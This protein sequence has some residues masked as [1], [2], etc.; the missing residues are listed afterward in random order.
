MRNRLFVRSG[1][2][3]L[4]LSPLLLTSCSSSVGPTNRQPGG[5]AALTSIQVTP[6]NSSVTAGGTAQFEAIGTFSDKSTQDLTSS[7]AWTSSN[8]AAATINATGL[9]TGVTSGQTTTISAN[10]ASINGSTS[11]S[12][13]AA[14]L[15]SIAVTPGNDSIV[16]GT[17]VQFKAMGTFSNNSTQDLTSSVTWASSNAA[18]ATINATGLATGVTS[19]QTATIS[20]KQGSTTGSTSLSVAAATLV[21]IVVTPSNGSVVAKGTLQFTATGTFSNNSTQDLTSSVTWSF[22]EHNCSNDQR[23]WIG[24]RSDFGADHNNFGQTGLHDWIDKPQCGRSNSSFDCRNSEQWFDGGKGHLA[25]H[26][27]RNVFKQQH[28]GSHEFGYL[29][30]RRTQLQQRSARPGW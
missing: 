29:E 21:S 12:V 28:T 18:A 20:A 2:I 4:S 26:G 19:G 9:A 16:T 15:V 17:T 11:L 23:D 22:V 6:A 30:L 7:V 27:N 24:H 13:S 3:L 10:Q 25:V 5:G 8:A 1:L 14:T